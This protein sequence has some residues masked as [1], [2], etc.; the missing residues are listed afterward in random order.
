MAVCDRDSDKGGLY[1]WWF[2]SY[3]DDTTADGSAFGTTYLVHLLVQILAQRTKGHWDLRE[4]REAEHWVGSATLQILH[5][6]TFTVP[7]HDSKTQPHRHHCIDAENTARQWSRCN[8]LW[9]H[10][11]GALPATAHW[12]RY[13]SADDPSLPKVCY[14]WEG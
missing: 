6:V 13:K 8:L 1:R 14:G 10:V 12:R 5:R 11:E 2:T 9:Q 4:G 7:P 3:V